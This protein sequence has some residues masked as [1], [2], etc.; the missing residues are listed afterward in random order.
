MSA[1]TKKAQKANP[2]S[3]PSFNFMHVILKP[4]QSEIIEASK[5]RDVLVN[6]PTGYGKS[7]LYQ[8]P[9][10]NSNKITVVFVPL[11]ALLWDALS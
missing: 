3:H 1:F 7:M 9:A 10:A 11:R 4:L 5:T 8:Y 2:I 6:L